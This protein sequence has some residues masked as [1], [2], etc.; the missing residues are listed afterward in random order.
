MSAPDRRERILRAATRLFEKQ[1]MGHTRMSEIA[2]A[3]KVENALLRY[4][5]PT[6]DAIYVEVFEQVIAERLE[7]IQARMKDAGDDPLALLKAYVTGYAHW[8][9]ER[10]M[11]G[12]TSIYYY[13][14]AMVREEYLK[15]HDE[16]REIARQRISN[17]IYRALEAGRIPAPRGADVA[18]LAYQ[19]Q[20]VVLGG[21][22]AALTEGK[23]EAEVSARRAWRSVAAILGC[24]EE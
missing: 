1:G 6:L 3:A 15:L 14:L 10:P 8:V 20:A 17:L 13:Y 21:A 5:F 22:V 23:I 24:V 16:R 11:N 4:H 2:K 7:F 9:Q 18:D 19:V 12:A